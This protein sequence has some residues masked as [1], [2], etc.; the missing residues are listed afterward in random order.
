MSERSFDE[1]TGGQPPS[2]PGKLSW[3]VAATALIALVVF[4]VLK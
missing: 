1:S 3:I 4:V 2:R